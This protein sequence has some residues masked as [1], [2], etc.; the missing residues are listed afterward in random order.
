MRSRSQ[1]LGTIFWGGHCTTC[2]IHQNWSCQGCQ[3]PQVAVSDVDSPSAAHLT[4]RQHPFSW[5]PS[6]RPPGPSTLPVVL[7]LPP[8]APH[9]GFLTWGK[10]ATPAS[11]LF[12]SNILA[13]A[14]IPLPLT[15]LIQQEVLWD[16]SSEKTQNLTMSHHP[17]LNHSHL[18][19]D[20]VQAS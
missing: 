10:I 2:D 1:V 11:S 8:S 14:L 15:R 18:S 20:T 3:Q 16:P 9:A 5:Y 13:V 4:R 6:P 19:L 17:C 7:L 12:R